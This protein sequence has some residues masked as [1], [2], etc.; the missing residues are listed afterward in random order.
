VTGT[1]P[2]DSK[3]LI[4][5]IWTDADYSASDTLSVAEAGLYRGSTTLAWSP[6]PYA[7]ELILCMHF[8]Q[9][10]YEVDT[11]RA[12][13]TGVGRWSGIAVNATFI[14]PFA[15]FPIPMRIAP[16]FISIYSA[17]G[18]ISK[19]ETFA[20]VE[21]GAA[22][23]A[24]AY[25]SQYGFFAIADAGTPYTAGEIYTFHYFASAEL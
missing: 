12:T 23:T 18:T 13:G 2:A 25:V 21:T 20:S 15:Q 4:V 14:A 10:S 19:V 24:A 5:A 7:Q 6:R 9:K 16:T 3:N 1:V 8:C 22:A 11:N 17:T